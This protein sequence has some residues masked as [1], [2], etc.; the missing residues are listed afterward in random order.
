MGC[1]TSTITKELHDHFNCYKTLGLDQFQA[2]INQNQT[3]ILN[4]KTSYELSKQDRA[5]LILL[6]ATQQ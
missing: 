5:D 3:F 4:Q 6:N 2:I 1:G